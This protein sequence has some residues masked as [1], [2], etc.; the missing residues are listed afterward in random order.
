L[1]QLTP[2]GLYCPIGGFYIDPWR[3]V[4]RAVITHGHSDHATAGCEHYLAARGGVKILETRLGPSIA[5]TAQDYGAVVDHN[6]VRLSLHPAG[7][8]LGSSQVRL[9]H[10][11]EVVVVSGDYKLAHDATC[12]AFEP[13][14]CHRFVTESTFG[15]PIYRWADPQTTFT[16]INAWWTDNRDRGR[17][18]VLYAY[19]LGKAQRILAAVDATIGPI[20][21][22]GA[23]ETINRAYR[24]S[25]VE[26]PPTQLVSEFPPRHRFAGA[27]VV[28]PPSAQN[29]AW[30]NRFEPC[31]EAVAS[32]WMAVRGI[33][34]RRVVD[35]GFVLSDH[36]DWE[37]LNE[38]VRATG[39]ETVYVTHGYSDVFA[40]WLQS[41]GLEAEPIMTRFTG[42]VDDAPAEAP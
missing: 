41:R 42:E 16:E 35:R 36:A 17:A 18:S 32:G 33:R 21:V 6:G 14:R 13:V 37:G 9:E 19:S 7:H 11:G 28:A 2:E 27:L 23:V 22:H 39:A 5:L 4:P 10:G 24:S 26:L 20:V 1:L 31:S 40:R 38:A 30:V 8:V 34:R 29:S 25:G 3:P 15:L 12:A